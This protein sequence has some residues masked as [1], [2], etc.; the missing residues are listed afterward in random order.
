MLIEHCDCSKATLGQKS[1]CNNDE[2]DKFSFA[3][4]KLS[5]KAIPKITEV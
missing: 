3:D 5:L 4:R 1:K 2:E